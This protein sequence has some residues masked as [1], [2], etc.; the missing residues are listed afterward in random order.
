MLR[1]SKPL[2]IRP[3][4]L[5]DAQDGTNAFPGA[6]TALTNLVP[7]PTT[8]GL[9][10]PRPASSL[11]TSFA[12]FNNPG[13]VSVISCIGERI[14]GMIASDRNIG[15]DEPFIYDINASAFV[16]ISGITGPNTPTTQSPVG[17]WTPP[18]IAAI[19]ATKIIF[20]HPGFDGVTHFFG[21]LDI[22]T[23]ASPAWSSG[24][25]A[26]HALPAV[27]IS[28]SGFNGRAYYAVNNALYFSDSLDPNTITN[29]SQVL[30]LGDNQSVTALVGLPLN[31]QLIGGTVQSLIAFK[32]AEVMYQ[33]TGDPA[34]TNLALN[35]MNVITGTLAPNAVAAT[36]YGVFFVAPDGVRPI[37][38]Q[39]TI[40]DPIGANGK[41]VNNPFLNAINPSRMCADFNENTLRIAVQNGSISGQ[42]YQEYWFDFSLKHWTGP[43]TFASSL[44]RSIHVGSNSFVTAPVGVTGKLF[45]SRVQPQLNSTYTENGTALTWAY[46]TV[47]LPDNQQMAMNKVTQ[48]S[49]AL[50][51][52][53]NLSITLQGIDEVGNILNVVSITGANVAST[54]WGAFTWGA[55][56]WGSV[57][58]YFK[59]YFVP[60]TAPLVFK[61][62]SVTATGM[63]EAGT[64]IGNL[65]LRYQ[66]LGY[67]LPF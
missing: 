40:G 41:G 64:A 44:M 31:N 12:G 67:S 49:I 50:Q 60:W 33:V 17:D 13:Q 55:A 42:P 52:P 2:T 54:I 61:Q 51:I 43:H 27:P 6:M 11:L 56:V 37:S 15:H 28:V 65:Y 25:T 14:Y 30:V 48:T 3:S 32:G 19:T 35:E 7:A 18:V 9:F 36:P 66:I 23:Y 53:A 29:A 16:T 34:T 26:S 59:Q 46:Q 8:A 47:L 4:G 24:N 58:G 10:I 21:T 63:S 57:T 38:F 39:G 5:S 22:T 1:R 20:T 45:S 62:M